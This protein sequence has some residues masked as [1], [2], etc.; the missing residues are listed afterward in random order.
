MSERQREELTRAQQAAAKF[1]RE[2]GL[3]LEPQYPQVHESSW[4]SL[5]LINERGVLTYGSQDAIDS[6]TGEKKD[7]ERCYIT[8]VMLDTVETYQLVE[9]FNLWSDSMIAFVCA[10]GSRNVLSNI[11]VSLRFQK[12]RGGW[13]ASMRL[14]LVMDPVWV[15]SAR[16]EF[17]LTKRLPIVEVNFIDS[18]WGRP[19]TE[20]NGLYSAVLQALD[21]S[22]LHLRKSRHPP[23]NLH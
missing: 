1:I 10:K 18:K 16:Y 7:Y 14:R 4:E 23:N 8:A 21:P 3:R 17:G 9:R 20:D 22:V 13:F 12:K 5:A 19:A 11:P 2:G 15:G 6:N